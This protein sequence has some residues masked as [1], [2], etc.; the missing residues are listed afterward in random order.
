MK[1]DANA[2]NDP[3][4]RSQWQPKAI[5]DEPSLG[6][7]ID[8]GCFVVLVRNDLGDWNPTT[9]VPLSVLGRIVTVLSPGTPDC[10]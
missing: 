5:I 7:T 9:H 3:R 1:R 10:D 4:V 2:A 6:V 8:D